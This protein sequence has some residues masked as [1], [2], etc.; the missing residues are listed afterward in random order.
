[1]LALA[2]MGRRI[3]DSPANILAL[4]GI[5]HAAVGASPSVTPRNTVSNLLALLRAVIPDVARGARCLRKCAS[6]PR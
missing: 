6:S 2:L 4:P 5:R 3:P 1:M